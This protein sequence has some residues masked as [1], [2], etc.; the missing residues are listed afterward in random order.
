MIC[1]GLILTVYI[2]IGLLLDRFVFRKYYKIEEPDRVFLILFWPALIFLIVML[3]ISMII[4]K[5]EEYIK[6]I[7]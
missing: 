6:N 1:G 5:V 4:S 3:L 2:I 7:L